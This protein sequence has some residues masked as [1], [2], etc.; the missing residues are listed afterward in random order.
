MGGRRHPLR[1]ELAERLEVIE[2]GA[3]PLRHGP[4]EAFLLVTFGNDLGIR[5]CESYAD[6]APGR[7]L[8]D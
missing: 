4:S 8:L 2:G 1:I 7:S 5:V 3:D 6:L